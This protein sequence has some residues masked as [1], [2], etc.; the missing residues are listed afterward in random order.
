[1][2]AKDIRFGQDVIKRL[3]KGVNTLANAVGST[4]GPGGRNVIYKH[5]GWPYITKDGVTVARNIELADEF[6]N[7][8]AQMVKEVANRTCKDAGDGTTTATI[9]AQ[10]IVNEGFKYI[11]S[12]INPIDIQRAINGAVEVIIKYINDNIREDIDNDEKLYNIATVSANWDKEIGD[13]VGKAI[14]TV[15]ARGTVIKEVSNTYETSL[16]L[17]SGIQFE[18]GFGGTE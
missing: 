5:N 1:M 11:I 18:R 12:G 15:G 2:G 10:A 8:G 4:L 17:I 6:E 13:I 16:N 9:L 3:I 7:I 14:S